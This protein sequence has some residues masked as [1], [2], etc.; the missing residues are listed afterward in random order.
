MFQYFRYKLCYVFMCGTHKSHDFK[1]CRFHSSCVALHVF[2]CYI[3]YLTQNIRMIYTPLFEDELLLN[4]KFECPL[5]NGN[6]YGI[7]C[8]II[9]N[10]SVSQIPQQIL[11]DLH[12]SFVLVLIVGSN[13]KSH[14]QIK[15]NHQYLFRF[16]QAINQSKSILQFS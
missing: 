12:L 11:L 6:V 13:Y 1:C 14:S 3:G 2:K 10:C 4:C 15:H 5:R 8:G 16:H 7:L 9:T